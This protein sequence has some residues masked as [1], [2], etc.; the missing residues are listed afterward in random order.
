MRGECPL[1]SQGDPRQSDVMAH[2]LLIVG[3][4]VHYSNAFAALDAFVTR[5]GI[6]FVDLNIHPVRFG[7]VS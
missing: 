1:D 7:I 5:L 6:P 4:G 3:G 2:V